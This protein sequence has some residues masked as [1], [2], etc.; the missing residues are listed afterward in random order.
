[1]KWF[2]NLLVYIAIALVLS[3]GMYFSLQYVLMD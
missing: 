2:R 3:F 1:M